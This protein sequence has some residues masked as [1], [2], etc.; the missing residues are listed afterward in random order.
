MDT[1]TKTEARFRIGDAVEKFG[2]DYQAT[3]TVRAV[4]TLG[5]GAIRYAVQF[6]EIPLVHILSEHQLRSTTDILP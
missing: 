3:G 4:F 2:G 5:N 1:G 6:N